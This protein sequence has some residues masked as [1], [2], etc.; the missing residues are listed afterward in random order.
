MR[1]PLAVLIDAENISSTLFEPLREK[2]EALGQ[3]AVWQLHGELLADYQPTW[4]EVAR[5]HGLEIHHQF[6]DG[7]NS[8]DIAMTVAAMD[9]LHAGHVRGFCIASSDSDFTPLIRRLRQQ[10]LPVYGFGRENAAPALQRSCTSFA[11]L[12]TPL[13]LEHGPKDDHK[14]EQEDLARLRDLLRSVCHSKGIE[15]EVNANVAGLHL[16]AHARELVERYFGKSGLVK[17]MVQRGLAVSR[18]VNGETLIKAHYPK[19]ASVHSLVRHERQHHQ[20]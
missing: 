3:P 19:L 5:Q 1:T 7:K 8:A 11:A 4:L 15:D 10:G 2:V 14:A 13:A 16:R 20:P 12:T 6:H 9:L 17:K 18:V